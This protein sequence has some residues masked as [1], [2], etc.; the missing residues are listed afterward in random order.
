MPENVGIQDIK[1]MSMS[2]Y[3]IKL[4]HFSGEN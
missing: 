4:L 3:E 1:I 2:D